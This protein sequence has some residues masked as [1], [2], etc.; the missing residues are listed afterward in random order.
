MLAKIPR[1]RHVVIEASAGTGKTYTIENLVIDLL[2]SEEVSL[3]E[4][5]VLTFTE[6][7]AT[8]LRQRIRSKIQEILVDSCRE[9]KCQRYEPGGA[10]RIDE[11]AM[12]RLSWA[13]F[14]FDAASIG[15]IHSFFGRILTEH[16]FDNGRLFEGTLEDGRLLFGRAFKHV[17]RTSLARRPGDPAELLELWL[18]QTGKNIEEL[19]EDLYK[20]H[21]SGRLIQPS[22]SIGALRRELEINPLFDIDLEREAARFQQVLKGAKVRAD[23]GGAIAIRLMTL[24]GLIRRSGRTMELMLDEEFQR[25]LTFTTDRVHGLTLADERAVQVVAALLRLRPVLVSLKAAMVQTCLPMVRELLERQKCATGQFDYDELISGVVRA[26]EGPR[27]EELVGAMRQRYRFALIDEFQDTDKLQWSFFR[28]VFVESGGRS[29]AYLIGDPKQAIYGFRGADVFTYQAARGALEESGS[30]CIPLASNFRSTLDM[31]E[32]YNHILDGSASEPFFDGSICYDVPVKPGSNL[33]AT[34]ADGSRAIPIRLLK[35]EPGTEKFDLDTLRRQLVRQIARQVRDLLFPAAGRLRFGPAE[36]AKPIEPSDVFILT[37]SNK[38]GRAIADALR[39]SDV[40]F[41][42]YKQ[43]GLFQTTEAREVR[44]LLAAINDPADPGQRGRAWITPFFAVPLADLPALADLPDSHPLL[45]KLRAWNDLA[46]RR[47]F[48]KLFA[49]ILDDSG[50]IRRE[51]FFEDNER[52]LTNYLHLFEILLEHT[53][54]AGCGLAD[55]VTTLDAYI[56]QTRKPLGEDGNV[57]RLESDRAAVQIMTI[58]KSKGLQ[59]AVVFVYGGFTA[60]PSSG[61]HVYHEEQERVLFLGDD[62]AASNRARDER[63]LEEQRLFYVA[64]TR[65]KARLYLPYIAPEHWDR[66]NWRG[67]YLRVNERLAQVVSG[68]EDTGKKHLFHVVPFDDQPAGAGSSVLDRTGD[69]LASC[70][71][72]LKLLDDRDESGW[73]HE[74]RK[75]HA[76]YEVTSYSRMKSELAGGS[77]LV[78]LGREELDREVFLPILTTGLSEREVPGGTAAGLML[79]EILETVPFDSLSMAPSPE[80]WGALPPVD[81]VIIAAMAHHNIALAYRPEVEAMVYRAMTCEIPTCSGR[82]IPNLHQI[83]NHLREMEFLFPLPERNHPSLSETRPGKLVIE[84]GFIK[85][86]VDLVIEHDGLVY[87]AD[88]KSDVLPSYGQEAIRAH[89][90]THYDLQVRLYVLALIKALGVHSESEYKDCF[91][92]LLYV[93]LRGLHASDEVGQGIYFQRPTWSQVLRYETEIKH[94]SDRPWRSSK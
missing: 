16:A 51:L 69:D 57:Q 11:R 6:R 29:I 33:V 92:G 34:E 78:P 82:S 70:L 76:G 63:R 91:G 18:K 26:L 37:V 50:I 60:F 64:M 48:E 68:L 41:A 77:E 24:S 74:H 30:P 15:T 42:F 43:D 71:R 32:A 9:T 20:C 54:R 28:R 58:H 1:G 14:A 72:G 25:A 13:A 66:K 52:G 36:Q 2:L 23:V 35:I 61:F 80:A 83:S 81:Q 17:L 38:D 55:L 93:F 21:A 5:L 40:P 7:A 12:Q 4:I 53:R 31:I 73:L 75:R 45:E 59:A 86:Y 8:E 3:D 44:D 47:R 27:G 87:F 84:R 39:D 79:H 10:W 67:G 85:G 56:Q 65:A 22:F 89:V 88:W 90:T 94:S 49:R 46:N 19:E 62:A